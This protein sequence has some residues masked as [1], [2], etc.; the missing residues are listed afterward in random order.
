MS[1]DAAL[2]ATTPPRLPYRRAKNGTLILGGGF[3]GAHVARLLGTAGATVVDPEGAML[4]T[5]L[6]PEVA[7]GA[8]EPRHVVVPLRVMCPHAAL[9]RGS[10]VALDEANR[11]VAVKTE[12][13]MVE[14]GYERLVIALG[15]TSR[16]LSIPGLAEHA[17]TFKGLGD[18]IHL[19]NHVVRKLETAEA[20]KANAARYLSFV[21][22]GAGYAGVEALT[23]IRQL[24]QDAMRHFPRL[25]HVPQRWV[26]VEAGP[27]ILAEG[28]ERLADYTA[29]YLRRQGVEILSSSTLR[30]VEAESVTLA[31]GRHVETET[32]VWTAGVTPH[33]VVQALG[34]PVD[35]R[36]RIV[37]DPALRVRGRPDIWALGDNARVPN[38]ATP[39]R[40]DPPTCQHAVR[41]ARAVV[42]S[43]EGDVAPYGYRSIGEGATLGRGKGIARIFGLHLRGR[44]GGLITRAYHVSVVPSGSRRWRI[45]ADGLLS[46]LLRR[47]IVEL[48]SI[49]ARRN[50]P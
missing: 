20:D 13:G 30:S 14:I 21:F 5:P 23:E 1:A 12:L 46:V 24:V 37:V 50:R 18:A 26:L 38:T 42:R 34:L 47:D 45:L 27:E 28:P 3:G 29:T 49:E 9:L 41:Q 10:A 31:D 4:F 16:V 40:H 33:P 32:V 11:R 39:L 15:S 8:I 7:A 17:I 36:G 19:R 44:L 48:G 6:L 22:V 2:L 43:L 25:R 35:E